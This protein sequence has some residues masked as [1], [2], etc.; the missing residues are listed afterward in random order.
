MVALLHNDAASKKEGWPFP[1]HKAGLGF[2]LGQYNVFPSEYDKIE[3]L[4][5]NR[6][7][8]GVWDKNTENMGTAFKLLPV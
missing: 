1:N 8:L 4:F 2:V 3:L 7:G 6:I 5:L